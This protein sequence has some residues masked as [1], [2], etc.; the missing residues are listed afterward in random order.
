MAAEIGYEA[1]IAEHSRK[2]ADQISKEVA[3]GGTEEDLRI[4]AAHALRDFL[5][6]AKP[7][8][9]TIDPHGKHEHHLAKGRPDS[10]YQ[11]VFIEYKSPRLFPGRRDCPQVRWV[12]KQIKRPF[13]EFQN[14]ERRRP[15]R[16]S[17]VGCL[18]DDSLY[19]RYRHRKFGERS[20]IRI[21]S[22]GTERLPTT[23]LSVRSFVRPTLRNISARLSKW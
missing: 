6:I 5:Q 14:G 19:V 17:G 18:G 4:T 11:G 8:F 10:V 2:V 12:V 22:K 21:S 16:L 23:L 1:L 15:E 3:I 9:S 13:K 20:L 7:S